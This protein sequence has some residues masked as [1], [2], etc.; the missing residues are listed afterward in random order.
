[1]A[2]NEK[3]ASLRES[4]RLHWRAFKLLNRYCPGRFL[5]IGL[6]SVVTAVIP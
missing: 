2:E 4:L 6:S 5:S 1:M 3:K